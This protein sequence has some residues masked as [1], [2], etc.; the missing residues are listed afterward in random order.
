MADLKI[1]YL[2]LGEGSIG[3]LFE[4]GL[5]LAMADH[6]A[7]VARHK[8]T[9][10]ILVKFLGLLPTHVHHA[11]CVIPPDLIGGNKVFMHIT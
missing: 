8:Y 1:V 11:W 5:E 7:E 10:S 2:L 3:V 9:S 6:N 4:E